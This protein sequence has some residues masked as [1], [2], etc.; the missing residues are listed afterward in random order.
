MPRQQRFYVYPEDIEKLTDGSSEKVTAARQ[1]AQQINR[2]LTA[3]QNRLDRLEKVNAK[4]RGK[5]TSFSVEGRQGLFHLTWNRVD[6]ATG[7]IV[8]VFTDSAGTV[9]V[10]RW[11]IPGG[12]TVQWQYPVGNVAIT[13]YFKVRAFSGATLSNPSS[14]VTATSLVYTTAESAPAD[15]PTAPGEPIAAVGM[16]GKLLEI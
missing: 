13:R 5:I 7:Y 16:G 1:V 11:D 10:G 8:E 4:V 12:Q 9:R 15:P 14:L 2:A 6:D 3:I